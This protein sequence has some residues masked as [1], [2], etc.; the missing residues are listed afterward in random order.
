VIA[1][2]VVTTFGL[3]LRLA[4]LE[5]FDAIAPVGDEGYYLQVAA[6]ISSADGHRARDSMRAFRPPAQAWLLSTVMD[7]EDPRLVVVNRATVRRAQRLEVVLG[8]LLV[9]LTGLLAWALFDRRTSVAAA[10]MTALFPSLVAFSHFLWSETLFA[11]LMTTA[12]C[13]AV[14]ANRRRGWLPVAIAGLAFGAAALTRE[15]AIPVA[16][17]VA[18]W[19]LLTIQRT[20][21]KL[22]FAQGLLMLVIMGAVVAPWSLRNYRIFER[23]V[24]VSNVGWFAIR[25]G[26]TFSPQRWITPDLRLLHPFRRDYNAIHDEMARRDF[27]RTEAL[28]LIRDEQPEWL[29]KKIVRT[30]TLLGTPD[31]FIFKKLSRGSYGEIPMGWIRVILIVTVGAYLAVAATAG[32]GVLSAQGGGRKLLP[33]LIA[34]TVLTLHLIANSSSRFRVPW[35]PLVIVYSSYAVGCWPSVL[36]RMPRR[37]LAVFVVILLILIGWWCVFFFPDAVHLWRH[38]TYV[39][40]FRM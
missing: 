19:W 22:A 24:L 33:L 39:E 26:N 35:M 21:W 18:F 15:V 1:L 8:G 16:G 5:V 25:E 28:G 4:L 17:V 27:A 31:S 37:R 34:G 32:I 40:A 6:H 20:R 10:V 11:V 7:N 3:S 13:S 23:P 30:V 14:L 9:P 2:T 12:L 29:L 36:R 38:G